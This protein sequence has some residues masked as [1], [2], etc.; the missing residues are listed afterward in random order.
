[1]NFSDFLGVI[2][3][4][5]MKNAYRQ[6][7]YTNDN[8]IVAAGDGDVE[9]VKSYLDQGISPNTQDQNGYSPMQ[10]VVEIAHVQACGC[11]IW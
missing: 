9:K 3:C 4:D 8:I 1:M 5:F 10:V 11:F 6:N 2:V 7:S